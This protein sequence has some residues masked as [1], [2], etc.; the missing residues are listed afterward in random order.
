MR[1]RRAHVV[2]KKEKG[3]VLIMSKKGVFLLNET[4]ARLWESFDGRDVDA[5]G[6]TPFINSLLEAEAVEVSDD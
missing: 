5:E 2:W 6:I 1:I 4:G 3:K